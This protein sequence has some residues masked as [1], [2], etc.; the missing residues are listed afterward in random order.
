VRRL[1]RHFD[2]TDKLPARLAVLF[3]MVSAR[4]GGVAAFVGLYVLL[5]V[6]LRKLSQAMAVWIDQGVSSIVRQL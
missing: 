4:E 6:Y 3:D 1:N 2:Y 5:E